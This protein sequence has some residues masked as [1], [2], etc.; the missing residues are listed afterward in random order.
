MLAAATAG[1]ALVLLAPMGGS[2]AEGY[3]YYTTPNNQRT[4]V[5]DPEDLH[6]YKREGMGLTK[7]LTDTPVDVYGNSQCLGS[8]LDTLRAGDEETVTFTAFRFRPGELPR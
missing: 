8:P 2:A 1:L 4:F 3:F 5:K 6:C 7:N